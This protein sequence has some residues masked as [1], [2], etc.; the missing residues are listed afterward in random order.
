MNEFQSECRGLNPC[1]LV[2]TY[3]FL[4][5]LQSWDCC[6]HITIARDV[7]C[8]LLTNLLLSSSA[9]HEDMW[10]SHIKYKYRGTSQMVQWV[11]IHLTKQGTWVWFLVREDPTCFRATKPV[12]HNYW[13]CALEP[14]KHNSRA[15]VPQLLKPLSPRACAPQQEKPPQW[16]ACPSQLQ[17]SPSSLQKPA[18]PTKFF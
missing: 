1:F 7:F 3:R 10:M 9:H 16:E 13:A 6:Y 8:R 5:G 18:R 14:G 4:L 17:S 15:H 12:L 11:R 2:R